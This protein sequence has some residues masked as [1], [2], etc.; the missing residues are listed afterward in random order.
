MILNLDEVPVLAELRS[1]KVAHRD[2]ALSK[3][4]KL[5]AVEAC[6]VGEHTASVDDRD[7]LIVRQEN[8]V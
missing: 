5:F 8:F 6:G 1:V 3:A 2:A 4:N 7:S